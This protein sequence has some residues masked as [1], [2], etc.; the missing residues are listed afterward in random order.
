M[1]LPVLSALSVPMPVQR[2]QLL[3]SLA[4]LAELV[5]M[6]LAA[7]PS[8]LSLTACALS[9]PL[10]PTP[11]PRMLPHVLNALSV[12][13]RVLRDQ[14]L[15]SLALLA[16]L[17]DLRQ[18]ARRSPLS[19]TACA[20]SAPLVG[21]PL[22][23]MLPPVLSAPSARMLVLLVRPLVSPAL[24]ALLAPPLVLDV[25]QWGLH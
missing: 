16:A 24:L 6:R 9:A 18:A 7:L 5:D 3:A 19:L 23:R 1:L 11:L 22:P 17:V 15:A 14:L 13:M 25:Q 12:P 20:L 4:L 21:S 10:V 2:D 8:P